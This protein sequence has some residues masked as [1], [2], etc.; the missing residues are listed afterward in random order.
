MSDTSDMWLIHTLWSSILSGLGLI[1]VL[2]FRK[3]LKDIDEK[4]ETL[5]DQLNRAERR[6]HD[7]AT[8]FQVMESKLSYIQGKLGF[9]RDD[10]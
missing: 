9:Q 6:R 8:Q 1:G 4:F 7:L 3:V 2:F 5:I 10:R